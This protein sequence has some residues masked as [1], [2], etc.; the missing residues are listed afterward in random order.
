MW[1]GAKSCKN[2]EYSFYHIKYIR[3][4]C[5]HEVKMEKTKRLLLGESSAINVTIVTL[6]MSQLLSEENFEKSPRNMRQT[7]GIL[8]RKPKTLINLKQKQVHIDT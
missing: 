8:E 1:Q 6:M 3:D 2:L 7:D 5:P 4:A